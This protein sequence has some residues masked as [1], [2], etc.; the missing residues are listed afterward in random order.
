LPDAGDFQD[1]SH[2][3]KSGS[4][5]KGFLLPVVKL[6]DAFSALQMADWSAAKSSPGWRWL[7]HVFL[8]IWPGDFSLRSEPNLDNDHG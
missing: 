7:Q 2:L 4:R 5:F 3:W 8:L 1:I 6:A